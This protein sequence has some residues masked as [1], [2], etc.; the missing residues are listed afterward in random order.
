MTGVIFAFLAMVAGFAVPSSAQQAAGTCAEVAIYNGKIVTM[1]R[2]GRTAGSILIKDGRI[3]A[4]G[5][6]RGVPAHRACAAVIDVHGRTVVPGLID[7]HAH[8]VSL[9][10]RPG[11]DARLE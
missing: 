4:V 9:G 11:H 7:N 2:Q 5:T 6:G 3:A 10:L 1:D 8:I